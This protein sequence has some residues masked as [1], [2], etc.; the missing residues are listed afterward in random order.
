MFEGQFAMSDDQHQQECASFRESERGGIMLFVA[1][2]I[3]VIIVFLALSIDLGIFSTEIGNRERTAEHAA[4]G[5]LKSYVE[6]RGDSPQPTLQQSYDTAL[7]RANQLTRLNFENFLTSKFRTNASGLWT[8][9]NSSASGTRLIPGLW[10]SDIPGDLANASLRTGCSPAA[11]AGRG[12]FRQVLETET[13]NAFRL[14]YRTDPALSLKVFF[15]AGILPPEHPLVYAEAFATLQPRRTVFL[16]DL[17]PSVVEDTHKSNAPLGVRSEYAYALENP[18]GST[19]SDGAVPTGGAQILQIERDMFDNLPLG[20]RPPTAGPTQHY[21]ADF[22]CLTLPTALVSAGEPRYA[23]DTAVFPEPLTGIIDSLHFALD[24]FRERGMSEDRVSIIPFDD[25]LMAARNLEIPAPVPAS[26]PERM[27]RP[28]IS[29]TRFADFLNTYTNSTLP[30]A[31]RDD[32]YLFPRPNGSRS[33]INSG[34]TSVRLPAATNIKL[35]LDEA[36][37]LITSSQSYR[38]SN[39]FVVLITDGLSNCPN[40]PPLTGYDC[41]YSTSSAPSLSMSEL[42]VKTA[43]NEVTTDAYIDRFRQA[44]TAVHVVLF[45]AQAGPHTLVRRR[46]NRC[47]TD[48]EA[49]AGLPPTNF[50]DTS[51]GTID[52]SDTS[53]FFYPN[54]L[55]RL[56]Q[57]TG[58]SFIAIRPPCRTDGIPVDLSTQC[59]AVPN[60]NGLVTNV[61]GCSTPGCAPVVV[62]GNGRL[63]C[64]LKGRTPSEQLRDAMNEMLQSPFMLVRPG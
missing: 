58:G 15:W 54:K 64:D 33:Y 55:Y 63:L 22:E 46:G 21:K 5:A 19:C 26:D 41:F 48:D 7:L 44:G 24:V 61:A 62:D 51:D 23:V 13:A 53:P 59:A 30:L 18:A 14:I 3:A 57:T 38:T 47:M 28:V 27:R 36:N 37:T 42:Y 1:L 2:C 12:C 11:V 25:G 43:V 34:G 20:P 4:L 39:N 32:A 50:V 60:E 45:G 29:D 31:T 40:S 52:P 9:G 17:S 10:L 56:A 16:V 6:S 49:R 35:A 8:V